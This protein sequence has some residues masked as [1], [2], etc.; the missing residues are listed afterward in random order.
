MTGRPL[1]EEF[2]IFWHIFVNPGKLERC[3][4]IINRQYDK[5]ESSGLLER[6][7]AIH[8]GYVSTVPFPLPHILR[9]NK[10]KILVHKERGFEGVTTTALKTFCDERADRDFALLYIHNRGATRIPD[11]PSEDWTLMMEY[12]CIE[13]WQKGLSALDNSLAAGCE[14]C[15][16]DSRVKEGDFTYHYSGNF[17]W[18]R[19]NYIRLLG[20]PTFESRFME[21]EDW[22]L[23]LAGKG[24]SRDRFGVLHR[25]AEK[26]YAVG[27]VHSYLDR[28]PIE[29]YRKANE[30]PDRELAKSSFHGEPC[31]P[32]YIGGRTRLGTKY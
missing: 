10:I 17:W 8:I 23:Q 25:T 18:A 12:F 7:A 6:C 13:N 4:D 24:I 28:Y 2:Y 26:R 1:D 3:K 9:N 11:T 15:A 20:Y 14:M 22:I 5:I 19:S 31:Y 21:S 16:H 27:M 29:Y 30:T 32:E